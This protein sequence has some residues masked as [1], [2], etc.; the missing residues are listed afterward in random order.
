MNK[1]DI[2]VSR[3]TYPAW[4]MLYPLAAGLVAEIGG[5]MTHGSV[6]ARE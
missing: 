3:F 4:T 2:L 6:V 5:L 1:G